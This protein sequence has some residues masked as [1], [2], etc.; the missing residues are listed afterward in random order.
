MTIDYRFTYRVE[1]NTLY[2]SLL[3]DKEV[4]KS[5]FRKFMATCLRTH[6]YI[7]T[8]NCDEYAPYALQKRCFFRWLISKHDIP[9]FGL[10]SHIF[11][12]SDG[13]YSIQFSPVCS[14]LK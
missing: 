11:I 2:Y 14:N 1:T 4:S 3:P 9:S 13:W 10:V 6:G 5:D 12:D 8:A 7:P